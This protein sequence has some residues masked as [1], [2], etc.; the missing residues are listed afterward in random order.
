MVSQPIKTFVALNESSIL[1]PVLLF[2]EIGDFFKHLSFSCNILAEMT[3]F[4]WNVKNGQIND[5]QKFVDEQVTF[6][7]A[8]KLLNCTLQF[9]VS[10]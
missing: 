8:T 3:S 4:I 6:N 9:L 7:K 2:G 10:V 1:L 5:V